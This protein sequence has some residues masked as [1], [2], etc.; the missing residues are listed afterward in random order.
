MNK[1]KQLII[2]AIFV[3]ILIYVIHRNNKYSIKYHNHYSNYKRNE[4]FNVIDAGSLVTANS[5]AKGNLVIFNNEGEI[6]S[7]EQE[8]V[9]YNLQGQQVNSNNN[10]GEIVSEEEEIVTYNLQGQQVNSNNKNSS[11]NSNNNNKLEYKAINSYS[12]EEIKALLALD[13]ENYY[14]VKK[15]SLVKLLSQYYDADELEK[16]LVKY[17]MYDVKKLV[18]LLEDNFNNNLQYNILSNDNKLSNMELINRDELTSILKDYYNNIELT[19]ILNLYNETH[20]FSNTMDIPKIFLNSIIGYYYNVNDVDY[21][22]YPDLKNEDMDILDE[23]DYAY[24]KG[25][26]VTPKPTNAVKLSDISKN[27]YDLFKVNN[28]PQMEYTEDPNIPYKQSECGV[29]KT[30]NAPYCSLY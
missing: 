30:T 29:F 9:T 5:T 10:K 22:E 25:W 23:I 15:E 13:K 16:I 26:T 18:K 1:N 24:K 11:K 28:L 4:G 21:Q 2:V 19:N 8:I 3:L 14:K 20:G 7:E 27:F 6:V 17:E 12:E